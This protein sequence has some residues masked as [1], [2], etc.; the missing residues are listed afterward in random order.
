MLQGYI[1]E[2]QTEQCQCYL[3]EVF[4]GQSNGSDKLIIQ[5]YKST[6]MKKNFNVRTFWNTL[7]AK[8]LLLSVIGMCSIHFLQLFFRGGACIFY[9]HI[10][11]KI[12]KGW[13]ILKMIFYFNFSTLLEII[14]ST[15]HWIC[16][17][18]YSWIID[19]LEPLDWP[20]NKN[21]PK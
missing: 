13:I 5:L 4:Q 3:G 7:M 18:L 21:Y 14:N 6:E 2:C 9:Y 8:F 17:L 12:N 1:F 11:Y 19:L 16:C 10:I 15:I 20:W